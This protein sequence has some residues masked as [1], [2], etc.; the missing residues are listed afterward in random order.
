MRKK[1]FDEVEKLK[2]RYV[3]ILEDVCNIESPTSDKAG[4][5]KVGEY[6]IR[7]QTNRVGK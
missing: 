2:D 4:V 7:W 5:D 6:F 3:G 1:I